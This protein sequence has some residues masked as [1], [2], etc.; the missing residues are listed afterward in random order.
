VQVSIL[1]FAAVRAITELDGETVTVPEGS[2][3]RD[4]HAQLQQRFPALTPYARAIRFA[5]NE[6]F[7]TEDHVLRE[8]DVVALIP[9]VAG[10]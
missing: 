8:G 4:L 2:Q 1:Y 3:V 6:S 7:A 10:G 9:P 5:V